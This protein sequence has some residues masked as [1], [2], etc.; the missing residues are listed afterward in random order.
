MEWIH[1]TASIPRTYPRIC[2]CR[3]TG[4]LPEVHKLPTACTA[5]VHLQDGFAKGTDL[6]NTY[7]VGMPVRRVHLVLTYKSRVRIPSQYYWTGTLGPSPKG[8]PPI[9]PSHGASMA[10]IQMVSISRDCD[11]MRCR[12][13]IGLQ[14]VF[15][16]PK[17]G[18]SLMSCSSTPSSPRP[19]KQRCGSWK[20]SVADD[21]LDSIYPFGNNSIGTRGTP[22]RTPREWNQ[23]STIQYQRASAHMDPSHPIP[24]PFHMYLR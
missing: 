1:P 2:K 19:K 3:S 6:A 17:R 7:V 23:S 24:C 8:R 4:K 11:T 13:R 20:C 14:C 16:A 21:G 22:S 12:V 10:G 5:T 18:P 9:R 15:C